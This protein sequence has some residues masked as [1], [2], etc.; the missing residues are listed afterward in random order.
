MRRKVFL[1]P[2]FELKLGEG[3][4]E[5]DRRL[6]RGRDGAMERVSPGRIPDS[7]HEGV[8]RL[9]E[10]FLPGH[11]E[12]HLIDDR[13]VGISDGPHCRGWLSEYAGGRVHQVEQDLSHLVGRVV[14][15]EAQVDHFGTQGSRAGEIAKR[16]LVKH[17]VRDDSERT[18]CSLDVYGTPVDLDDLAGGAL[19]H[20]PVP[21]VDWPFEKK[22]EARDDIPQRLLKR[23]AND[24]GANAQS[25]QRPL[26]LLAPDLGV[27]NGGPDRYQHEA[28]QITKQLGDATLPAAFAGR[29]EG[30]IIDERQAGKQH[31][32]PEERLDKPKEGIFCR[33]P[34]HKAHKEHDRQR[35][36]QQVTNHP[37]R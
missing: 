2:V 31:K 27:D 14:I 7:G 26:E 9:P 25:G 3:T 21:E 22:H 32:D 37:E 6:A 1:D 5:I 20:D 34:D 29:A 10:V 19:D 16:T 11:R 17:R 13:T 4:Q 28:G 18:G 35:G 12:A 23:Q 33:P 24:D 15:G 8:A 36:Q 30:H